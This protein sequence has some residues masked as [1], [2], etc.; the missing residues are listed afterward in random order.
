ML[1]LSRNLGCEAQYLY[2]WGPSWA[3]ACEKSERGLRK[4]RRLFVRFLTVYFPDLCVRQYLRVRSGA[5]LRVD[6]TFR[7][8]AIVAI[9]A[10]FVGPPGARARSILY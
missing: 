4:N 6:V 1:T 5:C 10:I 3:T 8:T 9:V 7:H 2:L